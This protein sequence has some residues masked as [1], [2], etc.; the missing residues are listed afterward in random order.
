MTIT[1]NDFLCAVNNSIRN[2]ISRTVTEIDGTSSFKITPETPSPRLG[3][4][5][6]NASSAH[7]VVLRMSSTPNPALSNSDDGSLILSPRS[8]IFLAINASVGVYAVC[9]SGAGPFSVVVEEV[10]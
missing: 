6:Y 8:T 7:E 3:V 9:E 1:A 5:I 10:N 4:Q 2:V